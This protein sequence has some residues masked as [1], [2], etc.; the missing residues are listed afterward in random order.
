MTAPFSRRTFL[1]GAAGAGVVA[2][3][4]NWR[5]QG[6]AP[7]EVARGGAFAQSV[8][9]GEPATNGITLWT[10]LSQLERPGLI[11]YE[12]SPE[13]DFR[14]VIARHSV[15]VDAGRDFAVTTRLQSAKLRPNEHYYY[16]FLTCD[17][18]SPVGRFKTLRPA[19]SAD[20][21]RIGFFSCQEWN[22]GFYTAHAALAEEQDLDAVV[23]LGDYVYERNYYSGPRTDTTGPNHDGD[24]QTLPEYREKYRLYHTDSNLLR[25]R[26]THP[27]LATWDDHEV[28]DN[29]AD[30]NGGDAEPARRVPFATRRAAGYT[31]FFEHMPK[32]RDTA[33][34]DRVYGRVTLGRHAD[35]FLL[36]ERNYR[37]DQPCG[38]PVAQPCPEAETAGRTI[39]GAEQK[40]WFKRALA[41][42]RATWK[43]V[44]NPLMI[45]AL[46]VVPRGASFTYDS[47][48]GYKAERR[49][50]G[51]FIAANHISD[52][53]FLT[54][55]IHT[56]FAGNVT[57]SGREGTGE[58]A[59]V[60]TEFVGG[61]ITSQGIADQ[62]GEG[63]AAFPAQTVV[64]ANNPHI[65]F[66]DQ[67]YKGYGV[68]EARPDELLVQ[69]KAP[70]TVKTP[71][72]SSFTLARFRVARGTPSVDVL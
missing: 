46:E 63:A 50:I 59:A 27:L 6:A 34:P 17:R 9:S 24:V 51:E 37:S 61:A 42:S 64:A 3:T 44:G 13:P 38:D 49:E 12:V 41:G 66:G 67:Q 14:S 31:A 57:P 56:F 21:I 22:G 35:L 48:D 30:G 65:K 28:E 68:L 18:S 2:L 25:V 36:D 52:V 29:Y 19:D 47:W 45:M 33:A 69:Y 54:G 10:K 40:A 58:P 62:Y 20:P 16:R 15:P 39:L 11:Q 55:D 53:A 1:A 5:A 23:C 60:A 7:G 71:T 8:A 43:L 26:E 4:G 72:A 32:L 70:R